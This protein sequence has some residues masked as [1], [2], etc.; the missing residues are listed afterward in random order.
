M[1]VDCRAHN[2]ARPCG[3]EVSATLSGYKCV[4]R[5]MNGRGQILTRTARDLLVRRRA[6]WRNDCS[7]ARQP[8]LSF[9][10]DC[11]YARHNSEGCTTMQSARALSSKKTGTQTLPPRCAL[12]ISWPA[13]A[14][15]AAVLPH[16]HII[17]HVC[18]V[19]NPRLAPSA[20]LEVCVSLQVDTNVLKPRSG[21]HCNLL[22][23]STCSMYRAAGRSGRHA[24]QQ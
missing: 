22:A 7:A 19:T 10:K 15:L 3:L 9:R 24:A 14:T 4:S 21:G 13:G 17:H 5:K 11:S 18:P 23:A 12:I 16:L 20:Q 1:R 8:L 6:C 2:V